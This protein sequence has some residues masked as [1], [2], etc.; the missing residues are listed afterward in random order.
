MASCTAPAA[1][2]SFAGLLPDGSHLVI[3]VL[4]SGGDSC[5][6]NA[7]VRAVV[8]AGIRAGAKGVGCGERW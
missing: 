5:G 4:T 6:M 3:G 7:S 1:E 2:P 8:R